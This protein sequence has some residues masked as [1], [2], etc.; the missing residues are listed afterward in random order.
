MFPPY[1][2][3]G[4]RRWAKHADGLT[5]LGYTVHVICARNPFKEE[6]LWTVTIKNNPNIIVH[7]LSAWYP[8][9]LVDFNHSFFK[10]IAYKFWIT[11]LPIFTKGSFLDRAIFWKRPM[12][13]KAKQI[14]KKHQITNVI[15]TGGPF[16]VMYYAVLLKKHLKNIFLINDLRDPWTWGPNWG[17]SNLNT[18]RMKYEKNL[19]YLTIKNS[20][21]ITVPNME[22]L[23]YLHLNYPEFKD[24]MLELPHFFDISELSAP[25]KTKSDKIRL[26]YYGNIYQD[27]EGFLDN[28]ASFLSKHK[29]KFIFDIYTDKKHHKV[30][31]EKYNADNVSTY[32]QENAKKLFKKFSN[33]DFVFIITPNYGKNNIATKFFEI[34]YTKTPIILYSEKGLAGEYLENNSLGFHVDAESLERK[35]LELYGGKKFK[36]NENF[37]INKYELKNVVDQIDS[38]VSIGKNY[39]IHPKKNLLLTFDYELFLG[40]K[41]GTA[42]NCIIAPTENILELLK[43]Y[44]IKKS[45]FF[46]DT[47]YLMRLY[48]VDND[49]GAKKDCELISKQLIQILKD[50]HYIFPHIHPHW[51]EATYNRDSKQWILKDLDKYRFHN[52]N[53]EER[54][55]LFRIS[56]NFIRQ[57]QE[58]ANV[59][60]DI[61]SYRAGGW[62]IQPFEDFKPYFEKYGIKNDFSVLSDFKLLNDKFYYNFLNIPYKNV[63]RFESDIEKED[64]NGKFTEFSITNI[65]MSNKEKIKNKI[66]MKVL[67]RLNYKSFGDGLAVIKSEEKTIISDSFIRNS[68][69][70]IEIASIELL[71]IP[72]LKIYKKFIENN[73]Y[74]HLITHPKMLTKHNLYCFDRYLKFITKNYSLET[75]YKRIENNN[76]E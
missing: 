71:T 47:I 50:G 26:V 17:F 22:M 3:I 1:Y 48:S 34:F 75:N 37:E 54:D 29:D 32:P 35:M 55:L 39:S 56:I 62:C 23:R 33:Y 43:K 40:A 6:S 52:I 24:K 21:I 65:T 19:E 61:D 9:V 73:S 36:F 2:G 66:F 51:L 30:F 16:G 76:A 14:I 10:K 4:G 15:A 46:V 63:Y 18:D 60:Y 5:K 58:S 20:D 74:I 27:I 31:F 67:Y 38:I 45:L 13:K 68:K 49:E 11:V 53:N 12:I 69:S 25:V 44:S 72:K 57:I 28:V 42:E 70:N 7:E 64:I 41:S 8:K 59:F